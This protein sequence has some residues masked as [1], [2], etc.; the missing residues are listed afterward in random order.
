MTDRNNILRGIDIIREPKINK[1]N[2][3]YINYSKLLSTI[4][5][6]RSN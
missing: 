2:R 1:V 5:K 3:K 6:V 4:M